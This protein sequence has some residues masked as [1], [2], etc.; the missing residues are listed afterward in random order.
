MQTTVIS[1]LFHYD[2]VCTMGS[3]NIGRTPQSASH[4]FWLGKRDGVTRELEKWSALIGSDTFCPMFRE[5]I[6]LVLDCHNKNFRCSRPS[7]KKVMG[8]LKEKKSGTK[9]FRDELIGIRPSISEKTEKR[10]IRGGGQ[11]CSME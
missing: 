1:S 6:V 2:L 4:T 7:K 9:K 11:I 8:P 10:P 5:T 3:L